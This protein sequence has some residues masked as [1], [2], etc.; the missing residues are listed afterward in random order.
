MFSPL[1]GK[2]MEVASNLHWAIRVLAT[3]CGFADTRTSLRTCLNNGVRTTAVG[4]KGKRD[5][6]MM[7]CSRDGVA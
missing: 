5:S 4:R 2:E 7:V 1:N 6:S 3:Q